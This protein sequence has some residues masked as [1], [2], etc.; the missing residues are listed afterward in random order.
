M[1]IDIF[2]LQGQIIYKNTSEVGVENFNKTIDLSAFS[3]GTYIV[4][5]ANNTEVGFSK[6]IK[7]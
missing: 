4:R 1:S 3:V 7:F 5:V 2:N 6:L